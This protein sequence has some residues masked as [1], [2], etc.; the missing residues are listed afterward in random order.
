MRLDPIAGLRGR[1]TQQACTVEHYFVAAVT[2][3]WAQTLH[4]VAVTTRSIADARCLSGHRQIIARMR[5]ASPELRSADRLAPLAIA[6]R[7]PHTT[8]DVRARVIAV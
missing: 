7:D 1:S 6:A 5:S 2:A 4:R 3:R 8:T